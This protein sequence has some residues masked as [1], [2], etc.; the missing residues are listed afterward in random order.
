[1]KPTTPPP[2]VT[3]LLVD[4]LAENLLALSALLERDGLKVITARSGAEALEALLMNDISLAFLDVQMPGMDGFELAEFMRG[5]ERSKHIPI[6]FVTA[7]EKDRNRTFRGY[8]AG[9]VD[10]LYKPLEPHLLRSK[11]DTFFALSQQRAQL[12]SVVQELTETVRLNET[13]T[14]VLGHDLRTPL[15]AMMTANEL[16]MRTANEPTTRKWL[17]QMKVSGRRMSRMI[18]ELLDFVRVRQVGGIPI[19]RT[20]ANLGEIADRV[21][22]EL[23]LAHPDRRFEKQLTGNLDGEW[24]KDRVAQIFSNLLANAVRHGARDQP[25]RM[26]LDGAS[27]TEV[28]IEISNGGV[29]PADKRAQLFQ[30]FGQKDDKKA[31]DGLGLGLFIVEELVKGHGGTVRVESSD[32]IGTHFIALMPR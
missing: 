7:G 27:A 8:E 2:P 22:A 1:M 15:S 32:A 6:I 12:Q 16:L 11:A 4:D 13:L 31:R 14:A 17:E 20:P 21:Y 30:P 29:I 19:A 24:D 9:A 25:V 5:A 3:F 26:E 18:T 23:E 10:F 28:R